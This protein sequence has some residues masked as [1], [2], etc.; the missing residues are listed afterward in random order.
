MSIGEGNEVQSLPTPNKVIK[1]KTRSKEYK[2]DFYNKKIFDFQAIK[3]HFR[4]FSGIVFELSEYRI[5]LFVTADFNILFSVI[6]SCDT[7]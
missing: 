3:Y 1:S 7:W 4:C 6:K 2:Q 5:L